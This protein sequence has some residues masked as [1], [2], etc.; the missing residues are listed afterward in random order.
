MARSSL[1]GTLYPFDPAVSEYLYDP[2]TD[3]NYPR[4]ISRVHGFPIGI[5]PA[6][7]SE[8]GINPNTGAFYDEL[9]NGW[10][11]D[12]S[13]PNKL[14]DPMVTEFDFP[15][16][17]ATPEYKYGIN[18]IDDRPYHNNIIDANGVIFNPRA[19]CPEGEHLPTKAATSC[20]PCD[21]MDCEDFTPPECEND[22]YRPDNGRINEK[23]YIDCEVC[24]SAKCPQFTPPECLTD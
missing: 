5:D 11:T 24:D 6:T 1:E 23:G 20:V 8:W 4:E 19:D 10:F 3:N 7:G 12:P 14:A 13:D 21:S 17:P 2:S 22:Q 15:N 16:N 9:S 18:P